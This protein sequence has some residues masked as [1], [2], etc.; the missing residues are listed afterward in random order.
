M[1]AK[2]AA[3]A[4]FLYLTMATIGRPGKNMLYSASTR[5][6][7]I[8]QKLGATS[9]D[10]PRKKIVTFV[11]APN[12]LNKEKIYHPRGILH[13]MSMERVASIFSVSFVITR[14]NFQ[15]CFSSH[16][17]WHLVELLRSDVSDSSV[18][19][20]ISLPLAGP[21]LELELTNGLL[22]YHRT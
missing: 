18:L 8:F 22:C 1:I 16:N 17:V 19:L 15:H 7:S 12:V 3:M 13:T 4:F 9:W 5:N 11:L 14:N 6:Q 10:Y 2:T 21:D 20:V